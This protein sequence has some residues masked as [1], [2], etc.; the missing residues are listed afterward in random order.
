MSEP[1]IRMLDLAA[2][3]AP[4]SL[5]R[6]GVARGIQPV[7]VGDL[8]STAPP[9]SPLSF[10]F[11]RID[12]HGRVSGRSV[13]RELRWAAGTELDF[14][15]RDSTVVVR[16]RRGTAVCVTSRGLIQVPL[17]MRRWMS[18]GPGHRLLLV[19]SSRAAVLVLANASI[20]DEFA[21]TNFG[22]LTEVTTR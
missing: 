17:A 11:A 2:I 4:P 5:D 22:V 12:D 15:L 9:S 6:D 14:V 13:L 21:Q 8:A 3:A 7:L 20:L 16:E 10:E 18:W 1:I 19:S